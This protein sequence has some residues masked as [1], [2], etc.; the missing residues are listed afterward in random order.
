MTSHYGIYFFKAALTEA[1]PSKIFFPYL[2]G[3]VAYACCGREGGSVFCL[4]IHFAVF[5]S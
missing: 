3:R 4:K 1:Q 5:K 2:G